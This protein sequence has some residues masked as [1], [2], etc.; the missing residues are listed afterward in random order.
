VSAMSLKPQKIME[1]LILAIWLIA[2]F[3]QYGF[4]QQSVFKCK[5]EDGTT[6]FSDQPCDDNLETHQIL[7]SY[8]RDP[9]MSLRGQSSAQPWSAE[10]VPDSA[11]M[12][13]GNQY[14]QAH[15]VQPEMN[16]DQSYYCMAGGRSWYQHMPCPETTT[17]MRTEY[18][19]GTDHTSGRSVTTTVSVPEE[20]P[21]TQ[22]LV[23]R[24]QA[25]SQ[26][27]RHGPSDRWG[28]G[29]DEKYT[30]WEKNQGQDPCSQLGY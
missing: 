28:S 8:E 16:R 7:E 9:F 23:S 14:P 6:I 25:C 24:R 22:K 19:Y 27:Y 11:S 10:E 12:Q 4:A 3:M 2:G 1:C 15:P 5:Q 29:R 17:V 26:I 20:I 30:T 13:P 21:V 18:A